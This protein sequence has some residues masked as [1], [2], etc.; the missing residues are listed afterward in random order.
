MGV[1]FC[2]VFFPPVYIVSH[3]IL[4]SF[5]IKELFFLKNQIDFSLSYKNK[6]VHSSFVSLFLVF[7]AVMMMMV[8]GDSVDDLA[9]KDPSSALTCV[10]EQPGNSE[11]GEVPLTGCLAS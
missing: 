9:N 11:I 5:L 10:S 8:H 2:F 7:S 4:L 3:P 6:L 1:L